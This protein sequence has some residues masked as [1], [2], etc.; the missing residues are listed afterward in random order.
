ML[1]SQR[2]IFLI[3]PMG[4]GKSTIGKH[5]AQLLKLEFF[6]TD[7]VIEERAGADIA[8]I[9]DVEGEEGFRQREIKVLDELTK[10][11]GLVLATGG[12]VVLASEN[13]NNLSSRGTVIYLSASI[14]Q[15]L[16]RTGRDKR[17]PMLQGKMAEQEKT[18]QSLMKERE[19]LY[20]EIAD[21]TVM[22]D[23]R[24]VRSVAQEIIDCLEK[25]HL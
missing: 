12:G 7:Q 18:L 2:S 22:T 5:L 23:G 6:D 19:T 4:A 8:W 25:E 13:R 9:F 14:D 24:T 11:S 10:M 17:R 21:Y 15:Q 16:K 3:G 1:F 20:E